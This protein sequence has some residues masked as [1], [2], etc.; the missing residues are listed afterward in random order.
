[1]DSL[2]GTDNQAFVY[3]SSYAW[4]FKTIQAA[5]VNINQVGAGCVGRSR[6]CWGVPLRLH[7]LV[8]FPSPYPPTL[9]RTLTYAAPRCGP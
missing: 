3:D 8:D 5:L 1:M 4:P 7:T 2:N 9:P 6:G